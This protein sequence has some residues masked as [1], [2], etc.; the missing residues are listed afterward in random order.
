MNHI[1]WQK[2]RK[3]GKKFFEIIL[4]SDLKRYFK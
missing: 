2:E 1:N 3:G 4:I